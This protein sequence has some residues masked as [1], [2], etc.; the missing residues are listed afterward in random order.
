MKLEPDCG[1]LWPYTFFILDDKTVL[2]WQRQLA[3]IWQLNEKTCVGT[4]GVEEQP[5]KISLAE[6]YNCFL[7]FSLDNFY[8]VEGAKDALICG[9]SSDAGWVVFC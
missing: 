6:E 2:K 7:F 9:N 3:F 8:K 4:K 5:R 1:T